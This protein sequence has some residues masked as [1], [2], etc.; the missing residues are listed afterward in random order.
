M[1]WIGAVKTPFYFQR[2]AVGATYKYFDEGGSAGLIALP[3]GT[4]KAFV[5]AL[6]IKELL[7]KWPGLRVLCLTHVHTLIKQN[8]DELIEAWPL[9]P[10]GICSAGLGSFELSLPIVF[11]GI[12]SLI[13]RSGGLGRRDVVIIDESHLVSPHQET[14][15]QK[16]LGKLKEDNPKIKIIGL[17]ATIWRL[18]Q[19]YLTDDGIFKDTIY[20]KTDL[21]GFNEI[22][23]GGYLVPP[24]PRRVENEFDLSQ[25]HRDG[26]KFREKELDA[27]S[28]QDKL[29][30]LVCEEIY[31]MAKGR[32]SWAIFCASIDHS[33][34]INE[35]FQKMGLDSEV[36]HSKK[37]GDHNDREIERWKAG[38]R[39]ILVNKDML[40]TGVNNPACDYIGAL[41]GLISSSL[42]VQILGRGT[43][44]C[45]RWNKQNCLVGDFAGNT[46]RLGPINDPVIPRKP[47]MGS[48]GGPPIRICDQCGSYNHASARRCIFCDK[49]FAWE[50]KVTQVASSEELIRTYGPKIIH[51]PVH[52]VT[53]SDHQGKSGK[54]SLEVRFHVGKRGTVAYPVW[55]HFEHDGFARKIS[56][57]WWRDRTGAEPPETINEA[58]E[59]WRE[60][61]KPKRI[62][63]DVSTK[64]P[65]IKEYYY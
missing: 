23:N 12:Q 25:V 17:S 4:G 47:G 27:A 49:E 13:N 3:T 28:N 31:E 6:L 39:R 50:S 51:Q 10:A 58:V 15:Y 63:V 59:R 20:N 38:K 16:V 14:G 45:P 61:R 18:G 21:A 34:K 1:E 9:A 42:W 11:G 32:R 35:L 44:T 48:N 8:Y 2:E 37:K 24:I 43:R 46:K 53:I 62:S 7:T 54:V 60:I 5:Q 29:N 26:Y 36:V 57:D 55:L 64:Y 41:R 40:T 33:E 30:R 52:S 19:G 65:Q 22:L 56:R